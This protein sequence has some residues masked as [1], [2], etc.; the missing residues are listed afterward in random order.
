MKKKVLAVM[1]TAAMLAGTIAGCG[2][3]GA[4]TGSGTDSASSGDAAVTA[5][6]GDWTWPLAEKKEL[7]IWIVWSNDYVENP[8]DLKAI[9]KMEELTNV[10]VNW[11]VVDSASAQEQFGLM[12]AS[13]EYPDII[14]D[15]GTYYPGGTEKG[16]QDGVLADLTEVAD[17]Y[18]PNYQ[19][20]RKSNSQLEKDTVTDEGKIVGTRTIASY[21]GDVKGERVWAGMALRGDWLNDLGL[22]VP[23]TIDQ[24]ETVLTAFKENYPECEAPLMIG[25]NGYDYFSHFLSAYGCLGE[26]Y[27]DGDKVKYGPLE[28]G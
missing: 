1:L 9:Q 27:K 13:G 18:M 17:K 15:C 24:W 28:D 20:L 8:N 22:E 5:D 16:V 6:A 2:S 11:Q 25:T 14:R 10:H 19:A 12:L 26:F 7:S 21:F 23:R 4:D 3:K